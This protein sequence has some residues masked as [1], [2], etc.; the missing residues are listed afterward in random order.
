MIIQL[1]NENQDKDLEYSRGVHICLIYSAALQMT[2][3]IALG[4]NSDVTSSSPVGRFGIAAN[5]FPVG[6]A[7]NPITNKIYVTN[8]LSNRLS[9]I[10]G[11]TD[12]LEELYNTCSLYLNYN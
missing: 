3:S 6:I 8:P 12:N 11:N 7:V 9:I 5:N 4:S 10:N 2:N 1:T